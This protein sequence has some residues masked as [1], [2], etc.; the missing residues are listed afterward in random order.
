MQSKYHLD[1]IQ[2]L[3]DEFE[4]VDHLTALF[5]MTSPQMGRR[6]DVIET[7]CMNDNLTPILNLIE[8]EKEKTQSEDGSAKAKSPI[9]GYLV[10]VLDVVMRHGNNMQCLQESAGKRILSLVKSYDSFDSNVSAMLQELAIYLKPLESPKSV[11]S[12]E[13][14]S[15]LVELM[16]RSFEFF[17]TFPGDLIMCLRIARYMAIP[18]YEEYQEYDVTEEGASDADND[19]QRGEYKE[20]RYK[21]FVVQFFAADGLAT[22]VAILE[23]MVAHFQQ[24]PKMHAS[25]LVGGQGVLVLQ[26]ILPTVQVL[27]RVLAAVI[28]ARH[29]NFKDLTAIT[30]L[31]HIYN[32]CH[33]IP[34][35]AL[36]YADA[37]K[38]QLEIVRILLCYTQPMPPG[39]VDNESV[40][41]SLWSQ[42]IGEVIKFTVYSPS[43]FIAGMTILSELLPLP[44][45][46]P[47][48]VDQPPPTDQEIQR[49]ITERQLWSAHLH[50]QT[51]A[52]VELIQTIAPTSYPPLVLLLARVSLQMSDLGPNVSLVVAKALLDLFVAQL[53]TTVNSCLATG[54]HLRLMNFIGNLV[55]HASVKVSVLSLLG[56]KLM[57]VLATILMTDSSDPVH[58]QT[59]ESVHGMLQSLLD[60]EISFYA[61]NNTSLPTGM[62]KEL[63]LACVIPAME[64]LVTITNVCLD[65]LLMDGLMNV[66]PALRTLMLLTEHE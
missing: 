7:I 38:A 66:L 58:C 23:K 34:A 63:A 10:D 35:T 61:H 6:N 41:K 21:M 24:Q 59:Q 1:A 3:T 12:Y 8:T 51:N 64:H 20:L 50:P 13:D 16:K 17:A 46:V 26:I 18:N 42:M 25:S 30:P 2:S 28:E 5:S 39:G 32:L 14:A 60:C 40:M 36:A 65:H 22:L 49:I 15:P 4:I 37:Q 33:T 54:I 44:L 48:V 19:G 29:V 31:L 53:L 45:P 52:I 43:S 47:T 57:E 11:F 55:G 27:R 9:L 62:S 56:P